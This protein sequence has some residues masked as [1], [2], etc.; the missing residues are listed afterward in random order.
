MTG[1]VMVKKWDKHEDGRPFCWHE[2]PYTKEEELD[3]YRRMD[4]GPIKTLRTLQQPPPPPHLAKER[5]RSGPAKA[6]RPSRGPR[7]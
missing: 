5:L 6:G 7:Q 4:A 3:F 2:P 1:M